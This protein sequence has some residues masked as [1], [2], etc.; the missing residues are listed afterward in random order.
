MDMV[1]LNNYEYRE[2]IFNANGGY[3]IGGYTII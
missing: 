2:F 1:D 3:T